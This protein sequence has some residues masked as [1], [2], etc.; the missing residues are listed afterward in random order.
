MVFLDRLLKR[1]KL[2]FLSPVIA[3]TDGGGVNK[4]DN[5]VTLGHNLGAGIAHKLALDTGTY[6]RSLAA[7]QGHCLSH[8]VRTHQRTV[9]VIMLQERNQ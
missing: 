6:D 4:L 1:H 9:G 5:T 8:H 7:Q 3:Y 2:L